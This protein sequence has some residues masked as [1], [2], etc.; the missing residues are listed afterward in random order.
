MGTVE[1]VIAGSV[2]TIGMLSFLALTL[3]G[4]NALGTITVTQSFQKEYAT[5]QE[6]L[7]TAVAPSCAPV[8]CD[9]PGQGLAWLWTISGLVLWSSGLWYFNV[10][11]PKQAEKAKTK[12]K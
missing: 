3:L 12:T 1:G 4:T 6:Q 11:G 10:W 8:K 2:I 9:A 7:K 5:C